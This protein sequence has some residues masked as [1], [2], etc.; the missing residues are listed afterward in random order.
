[1]PLLPR[2]GRRTIIAP[3]ATGGKSPSAAVSESYPD[4]FG[5][6]RNFFRLA[7]T[8]RKADGT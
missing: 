5:L 8:Y 6:L 4:G 2:Q 7:R 3:S 1:M